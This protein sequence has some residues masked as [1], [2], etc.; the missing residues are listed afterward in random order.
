MPRVIANRRSLFGKQARILSA[1]LLAL[2]IA[3]PLAAEPSKKDRQR[4][5]ADMVVHALSYEAG[6]NTSQRNELLKWALEKSP[7]YAPAL[8]HSGFVR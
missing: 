6:G 3:A 8:W 4:A 5:A 2:L 7:N 1:L